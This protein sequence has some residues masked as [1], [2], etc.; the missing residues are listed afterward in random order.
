[1]TS[2]KPMLQVIC[3]KLADHKGAKRVWL[4]GRRLSDA[5]FVP[6][7]R[8]RLTVDRAARALALDLTEGTHVVSRKRVNERE[9][10]VIDLC[11]RD[12]A[13]LFGGIDRVKVEIHPERIRLTV[14]PDDAATL[15]R[16][17]RLLAKVK[18]GETLNVGSIAHGGGILD[19]A[20]HTGLNQAGLKSRLAFAVEIEHE[21]LESS[22]ANSGL[23]D[24]ESL[25]IEAPME[26]VEPDM[27][28]KVE[29]LCAGLP[30]TGAS[31]SGRAKNGLK[32][33][34]QHE[35]AGTLFVA[36]LRIV[37]ACAPACL[38]FENVVPYGSTVSF[39][40]VTEVLKQWGYELHETVL[41]GNQMG[42]IEDRK[43]LCLVAVTKGVSFDLAGLQ[44]V[45]AK[46]AMLGEVLENVPDDSPMWKDYAYLAAKE[47]RDMDAGKGFRRQLLGPEAEKCGTVGRGY[48][49][50][51][52]TEPFVKHPSGDGRSRLLTPVEH[53]RVKTIPAHLV[54]GLS[55]TTAHEI[56]GQSVIWAAFVAVAKLLGE[57]LISFGRDGIAAVVVPVSPVVAA[58]P[59]QGSLFTEAAA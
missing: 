43:R 19:H 1:M 7:V 15:E 38:I 36:F 54:D 50:C 35:T 47:V 29:V 5:G 32:F 23:W 13:E 9:V 34:E 14:H 27:L 45:R 48:S 33:A 53:A 11:N 55:N 2:I 8:Y 51:R 10:P 42:A 44:T 40:V 58:L 30:C 49:K 41:D 22:L 20:V 6:G 18:S 25:A 28:P 12:L 17:E 31:L 16:A 56:L 4:E 24:S 21:Y 57:H 37:K 46:E 52:S 26:E 39:H 3:R 59:S